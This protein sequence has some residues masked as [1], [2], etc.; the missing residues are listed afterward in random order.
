MPSSNWI[1][2]SNGQNSEWCHSSHT[3]VLE[4]VLK[5]QANKYMCLLAVTNTWEKEKAYDK[6]AGPNLEHLWEEVGV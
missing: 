6:E 5:L 1:T 4:K 2:D 3:L